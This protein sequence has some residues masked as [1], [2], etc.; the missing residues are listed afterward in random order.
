MVSDAPGGV[1]G[2]GQALEVAVVLSL[3]LLCN[4]GRGVSK[5]WQFFSHSSIWSSAIEISS[6]VLSGDAANTGL[7]CFGAYRNTSA[8]QP[9]LAAASCY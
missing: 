3:I 5:G 2:A 4:A 6:I 8:V 7:L 9:C 1:Q